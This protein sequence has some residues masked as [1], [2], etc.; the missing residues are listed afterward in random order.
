[1]EGGSTLEIIFPSFLYY[2]H[3]IPLFILHNT[4]LPQ[5]LQAK[6][7]VSIV[8]EAV[9]SYLIGQPMIYSLVTYLQC[10][11]NNIQYLNQL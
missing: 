7:M 6:I 1:M 3:E 9:S 11:N 5:E 8:K 10:K 4:S 2:P